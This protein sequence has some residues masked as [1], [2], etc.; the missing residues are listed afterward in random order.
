MR[1]RLSYGMV[2]GALNAFIGGVHRIGVSFDGRAKLVAG[3]FSTNDAKNKETGAFY[4][5]DA[6]RIYASYE[7]MAVKEG[8]RD[9]GIDFV[10]I[11][12]PNNV[13]FQTAKAFLMNGIHVLCEKPSGVYSPRTMVRSS[14]TRSAVYRSK[15][16]IGLFSPFY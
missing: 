1:E 4:E 12:A 14:F 13:H 15:S 11:T 16:S 6:D 9:D 7:D 3:C 10:T 2:G 8:Q 5:L